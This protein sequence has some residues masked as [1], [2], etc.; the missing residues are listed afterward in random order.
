MQMD[1][2]RRTPTMTSEGRWEHSP[3][4]APTINKVNGGGEWRRGTAERKH[5]GEHLLNGPGA[6]IGQSGRRRP[7]WPAIRVGELFLIGHYRKVRLLL[8]MVRNQ[9]GDDKLSWTGAQRPK[10][11]VYGRSLAKMTHT[12]T[13]GNRL[14][15]GF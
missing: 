1:F 5:P 9:T 12:D 2:G 8:L 3:T 7:G 15:V 13:L 4:A 14:L 10:I 6:G 11:L